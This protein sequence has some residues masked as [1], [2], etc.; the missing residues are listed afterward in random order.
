MLDIQQ[1]P[2]MYLNWRQRYSEWDSRK[3]LM[4]GVVRG[5]IEVFDPDEESVANRSPNMVQI[6]MEDTAESASLVPTLRVQPMKDGP[7]AKDK[8]ARMEQIGANYLQRNDVDLLIPRSV[9]DAAAYGM[10]VWTITPDTEQRVPLIERRDPRFCY[11]EP[12]FRPGDQPRRVMFAR[13]VY[14]TQLPAA[15]QYKILDWFADVDGDVQENSTVTVVEYYDADEYVLVGMVEGGQVNYSPAGSPEMQYV[16]IELERIENKVSACPVV[17][18]SRITLDGE[19]RGQFDQ[20]VG[21]LEAHVRLM[22]IMLDYSDQAVYSDIWVRD[23][24]GV[25]PYGGGS[26]IE[27]GPNG[28][29]GR[30]PPAVSSLDV[31]RDLDALMDNIHLGGRWPKGRPGEIDQSIASAKFLEASAG[32]MNTAIR[33]YHQILQRA[34]E[35]A[36]RLAYEVDYKM[37]PGEKRAAGTLRNQSFLFD[38]DPKL[39]IDLENQ[40]RVEYGLGLGRDA[41]QSAVL[42]IQY[43]QNE[44]ISREFVME[45]IDGMT[46]VARELKRIDMEKFRSMALAKIMQG[47]EAG[48][49]PDSALPEIAEARDKG[50]DLFQI[51]QE[52]I[53]KPAE[54][55]AQ[56]AIPS[57]L[58]PPMLPGGG[59]PVPG[60]AP[61]QAP[62]VPAPPTGADLLARINTPAGPGGTLGAQ[63]MQEG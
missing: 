30:V 50:E 49:I 18:G 37:F 38:Y 28:A 31:Q 60:A 11:P 44:Y 2:D 54:E 27:L 12:G 17:I 61:G 5:D 20:V 19:F 25:L 7:R 26:Y 51:Y 1:L 6:A 62:G 55:Q 46:D 3:A 10:F 34:F 43:G 9:M 22:G 14:F 47:L 13:N 39:D 40:V 24:I 45:N 23:L 15:Y 41:S 59:G 42:H 33:T 4:D 56:N 29:I 35:R 48:T 36:L 53:V 21:L 58:G 52:Y 16:P 57:G 8:A 63:V 32:M